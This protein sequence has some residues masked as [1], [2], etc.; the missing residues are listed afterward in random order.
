MWAPVPP[1][2]Q[3]G[4]VLLDAALAVVLL[5]VSQVDVWAPH[6]AVWGDDPVA[7][8]ERVNAV[9]LAAVALP[10]AGR[11]RW[12]LVTVA[13]QSAAAA[14]QALMP[15]AA[16]VGLLLAGPVLIGLYSVAAY[17]G[18]RASW[19]GLA[20]VAAAVAVHDLTDPALRADLEGSSWWWLVLLIGWLCGRYVGSRRAGAALEARTRVLEAERRQAETAVHEER[21]RIA[22][23]LHDVVAHSVSVV[24]VQA[25][26]AQAVLD[27]H[28]DRAREPLNAIESTARNAMVEMRRL[29]GV[30]RPV[31]DGP[32]LVPQPGLAEVSGLAA[33]LTA[34]GLPVDVVV[35][36]D[37]APLAPGLE[38]TAHRIVQEALTNAL[39][40]S[41]ATRVQVT[42]GYRCEAVELTVADDGRGGPTARPGGHGIVGMRERVT[43]YGGS[44]DVG[45][46]EGGGYVV[47]AVL[48]REGGT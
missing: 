40:H 38:L 13:V 44:L 31:D 8:D 36:G 14:T 32:A 47:R 39:R 22:R 30:L 29:L 25:G 23:E 26:A 3:R 43:L 45:P 46:A 17:G 2:R 33:H 19:A 28:P 35:E 20:A 9:L 34:A 21:A 18:R 42:I 48:P 12:P 1:G 7:G 5:L 4:A 10:L 11:R 16:P 41:R 27:I 6:L 24:A 15:G 37:P